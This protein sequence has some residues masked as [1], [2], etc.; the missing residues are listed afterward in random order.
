VRTREEL[1]EALRGRGERLDA[2]E[3]ES[4]LLRRELD[5]LRRDLRQLD[6]PPQRR[7]PLADRN[8]AAIGAAQTPSTSAEKVA[9]FR[10]LF[11]GRADV[12]P[13]YWENTKTKKKGYAPACAN[14]WVR[15]VCERPRI[16]CGEC[17][18]QAFIEVDDRRVLEHLQGHHVMGVYPML[19]GD[20]CWFLAADFD[21]DA[22]K[23]DVLAFAETCDQFELPVAIERSRSGNGAHAW[24]FFDAPPVAADAARRVGCF[25]LT[26]TMTRRHQLKMDSYDRLFPN[27]DTLPK[28][29][30][31][32]LIALPLQKK[33]R[34]HG[35]TLFVDRA[36]G[37][38]AD[39]W[40]YL[41]RHPRISSDRMTTLADEATCRGSVVGVQM[42]PTGEEDDATPWT[43][44]HSGRPRRERIAE[45][46]PSHVSAGFCQRLFIENVGRA[47]GRTAD[48]GLRLKHVGYRP[49]CLLV[50]AVPPLAFDSVARGARDEVRRCGEEAL[51]A[52]QRALREKFRTLGAGLGAR[53]RSR[54]MIRQLFFARARGRKGRRRRTTSQRAGRP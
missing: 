47:L 40:A 20:V 51:F 15:G 7:L 5:G 45:V 2:L 38:Y 17:P 22:W 29:G 19:D 37:P 46:L 23:D 6:E 49:P 43:R 3:H 52:A 27:Q 54:L 34:E 41:A 32:N 16:K 44:R 39:P 30:F 35:N 8:G 9:L 48:V 31:G 21:K 28:G 12:F 26:E 50:R 4:K 24:F 33:A 36:L 18:S 14:E 42:S 25:L 11:R 10:A 1:L 53:V 13:R